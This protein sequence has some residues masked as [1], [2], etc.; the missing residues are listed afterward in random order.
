MEW[1]CLANPKDHHSV[2]PCA[3]DKLPE[4]SINQEHDSFRAFRSSK[5][6]MTI[7]FE[8]KSRG[9]NRNDRPKLD[10]FSSTIRWF[11]NLKFIFS[12]A[13]RPIR[14][15]AQF[16][17]KRPLKPSLS[18]HFKRC[19]VS[20]ALHQFQVNYWTSFSQQ[21]GILLNVARGISLSA[22]WQ[23]QLIPYTDGLKRRSKAEYA[24]TF[25]NCELAT[26]NIWI[27]SAVVQSDEDDEDPPPSPSPDPPPSTPASVRATLTPTSTSTPSL[28]GR[29]TLSGKQENSRNMER[30]FLFCV[31]KV[32]YM[33]MGQ[34]YVE[35]EKPTHKLV[36]HGARGAYTQ[37]NRDMGI[38]L[39]DSWRRAQ[40]LRKNVSSDALKSF[41]VESATPQQEKTPFTSPT[42]Q[43]NHTS[44]SPYSWSGVRAAGS[45]LDKLLAES[46]GGA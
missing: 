29:D 37:S 26:S 38:A 28:S 46:E 34:S 31:E 17:N 39:Y 10:M 44:G 32:V 13:S 18:R 19:T 2:I 8:T 35:E 45:M 1:L 27:Q 5:L 41:H 4:Y 25:I 22:E 23:L 15:G 24:V 3:P 43:Q 20:M 40:I 7:Q 30:S 21:R 36:I 14:R 11:E 33:R 12:G 42:P 16:H 6:N 9:G